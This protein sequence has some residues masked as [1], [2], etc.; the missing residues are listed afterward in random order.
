MGGARCTPWGRGTK[1]GKG[2]RGSGFAQN[3]V[4]RGLSGGQRGREVRPA[5]VDWAAAQR[6]RLQ[7]AAAQAE[8]AAGRWHLEAAQAC[9]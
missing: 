7:A 8:E 9:G 4:W 5:G 3:E 1:R 2:L 6:R